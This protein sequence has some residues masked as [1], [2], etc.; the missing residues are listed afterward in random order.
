M[1]SRGELLLGMDYPTVVIDCF[2]RP[3][4]NVNYGCFSGPSGSSIDGS[5]ISVGLS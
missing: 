5:V 1:V 2:K 4:I 3:F